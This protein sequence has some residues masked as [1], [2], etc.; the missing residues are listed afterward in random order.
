MDYEGLINEARDLF[1]HYESS[2]PLNAGKET[3]ELA[4]GDNLLLL[5]AHLLI[6][7]AFRE[8]M[9]NCKG[10]YRLEPVRY[11]HLLEAILILENGLPNSKFSFQ[12]KILLVQLYSILGKL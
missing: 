12:I 9:F 3:T 8:G 2:I 11:S 1:T 7:A 6:D 10:P 5:S 4:I